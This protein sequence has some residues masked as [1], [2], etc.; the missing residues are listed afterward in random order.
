MPRPDNIPITVHSVRKV[1]AKRKTVFSPDQFKH[2]I[3]VQYAHEFIAKHK[4]EADNL[5]SMKH[6]GWKKCTPK[7]AE[8]IMP[9]KSYMI[10]GKYVN[11]AFPGYYLD[12][13]R[14]GGEFTA[15]MGHGKGFPMWYPD[16]IMDD[17]CYMSS[18]KRAL[19]D[20]AYSNY[21][22]HARFHRP[23]DH[24]DWIAQ[25]TGEDPEIVWSAYAEYAQGL[26]DAYWALSHQKR[27]HVDFPC[28]YSRSEFYVE[29]E[30]VKVYE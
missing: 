8:E 13:D 4:D 5:R 6:G 19:D 10:Q 30:E 3:K 20:I 16:A 9:D 28:L 23:E 29:D 27:R 25:A 12:F 18:F 2:G 22:Q 24:P 11:E 7:M 26:L 17:F 21:I 15:M 14:F 1:M